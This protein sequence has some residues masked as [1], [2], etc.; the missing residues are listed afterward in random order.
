VGTLP[1]R[2]SGSYFIA[3]SPG[4]GMAPIRSGVNVPY[5]DEFR[6][7]ATNDALLGQLAA[8]VPKGGAG[9]HVIEAT[10]ETPPPL[11]QMLAVNTFRHD[12]PKATS[13]QDIW[14]WLSAMACCIFFADIFLRRVELGFGWA[15][16]LA[17]RVRCWV[18]RRQPGM[19]KEETIQRLQ[20]RKAEVSGQIEQR[21][22]RSGTGILP[23]SGVSTGGTPVIP[24]A[25]GSEQQEAAEGYTERLLQA[26]KKV[27]EGRGE[28]RGQ[29]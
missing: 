5:S 11:E 2:D 20:S 26:K 19:E 15:G 4:A 22:E 18:T 28:N 29:K 3:V 25:L 27:W 17:R 16:V 8:N 21:R 24:P 7:R 14:H 1:V 6:D 13:S 12:L 10:A 23:A 9:G